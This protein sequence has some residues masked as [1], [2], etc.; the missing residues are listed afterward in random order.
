MHNGVEFD[1]PTLDERDQPKDRQGGTLKVTDILV[2]NALEKII[3]NIY[4]LVAPKRQQELDAAHAL[5]DGLGIPLYHWFS[6]CA[7]VVTGAHFTN[8]SE[9]SYPS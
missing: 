7:A 3:K 9:E 4:E 5:A 8:V 2:H 1:E 6:W